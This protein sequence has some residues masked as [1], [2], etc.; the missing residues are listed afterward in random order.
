LIR[1]FLRRVVFADP[2][3]HSL[4]IDPEAENPIAIRA[5]EKA[6]FRFLRTASDDGDGHS[7]YLMEMR[8]HQLDEP[9]PRQAAP[10]I[11]PART[12]ELEL[13]SEIDDDACTAYD[14]LGARFALFDLP[15][16][17]PFRQAELAHWAHAAAEE[18]AL[19]TCM[20]DGRPCGFAALGIVDGLPFLHQISIRRQDA[21]RGIG[22]MLLDRC[23]R[24]AV[25]PGE[26]WLTTYD[27]VRWNGPWY[28][29]CGFVPMP[30]ATWGPQLTAIFE[31]EQ[32]ALPRPEHRVVM[33]ARVGPSAAR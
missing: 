5:Y 10:Y 8:R 33:R 2:R 17:H 27:D 31:A 21:Q 23:L 3:I 25:Q 22:R 7:L 6:G 30:R 13:L 11:R 20:P 28:A 18:R 9:P 12:F 29:R 24:W 4:V 32:A 14:E 15:I 16:E 26:L 1:E 19:L